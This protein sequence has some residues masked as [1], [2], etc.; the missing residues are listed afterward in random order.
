MRSKFAT[1][2]MAFF[3]LSSEALF[4]SAKRSTTPVTA[5]IS[6][7][8]HM[9]KSHH[10]KKHSKSKKSKKSKGTKPTKKG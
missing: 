10:S 6:S 9:K 1:L 2:F 8:S 7:Q 3:L 5:T 4:A